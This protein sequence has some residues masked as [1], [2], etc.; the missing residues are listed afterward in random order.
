MYCR[1]LESGISTSLKLNEGYF[2]APSVL[3][4]EGEKEINC[5]I[6]H[7]ATAYCEMD[8]QYPTVQITTGASTSEGGVLHSRQYRQVAVV[9]GKHTKY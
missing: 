6:L 1:Q 7:I 2:E 9:S 5:L 4:K 3:S 8:T